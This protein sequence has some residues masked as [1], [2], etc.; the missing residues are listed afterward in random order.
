[1]PQTTERETFEVLP[2]HY[3]GLV[4][5][6]PMVPTPDQLFEYE[7]ELLVKRGH[8]RYEDADLFRNRIPDKGLFVFV[9]PPPERLDLFALMKKVCLNHTPGANF[10][11]N[12]VSLGDLGEYPAT[13]SLLIDVEDG[14]SR[15]GTEAIVSLGRIEAEGRRPYNVWRG[16]IHATLFPWVLQHHGLDLV[17]SR[18]RYGKSFPYLHVKSRV[19]ILEIAAGVAANQPLLSERLFDKA[20]PWLGAPSAGGVI[21][22]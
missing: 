18:S 3:E 14:R 4:A 2:I 19:G 15:L 5:P 12:E 6:P 13:A 7:V 16:I 21:V 1:M 17:G 9:P 11:I 10:Y 8:A 22:P 20:D